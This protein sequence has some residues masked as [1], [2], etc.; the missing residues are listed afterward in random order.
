M[1]NTNK[2]QW[3]NT[4]VEYQW[5]D[6]LGKLVEISKEGYWYEGEMELAVGQTIAHSQSSDWS[7]IVKNTYDTET[8]VSM[9]WSDLNA[10]HINAPAASGKSNYLIHAVSGNGCNFQITGD[11]SVGMGVSA[12]NILHPLHV[13]NENGG[14]QCLFQ[15]YNGAAKGVQIK[16]KANIKFIFYKDE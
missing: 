4:S 9:G 3:I 15:N 7:L 11:G 10:M 6:E 16:I 13:V 14:Y 2:K 5:S 8:V 1:I 12:S